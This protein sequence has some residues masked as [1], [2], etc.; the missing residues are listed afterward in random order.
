MTINKRKLRAMKYLASLR[1]YKL[2]HHGKSVA[3]QQL[4]RVDMPSG[5]GFY[6][7]WINIETVKF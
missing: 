6:L 2:V 7:N 4:R 1:G 5:N 3:L